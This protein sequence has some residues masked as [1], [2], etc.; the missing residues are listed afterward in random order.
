MGRRYSQLLKLAPRLVDDLYSGNLQEIRWKS[1]WDL[2]FGYIGPV[3]APSVGKVNSLPKKVSGLTMGRVIS[4]RYGS[5]F[6]AT[7]DYV[8]KVDPSLLKDQQKSLL[9]K[10]VLWRGP[11]TKIRGTVIHTHGKNAVMVRFRRGLPGQ[12]IGTSVYFLKT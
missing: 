7:R 8:I 11:H 5:A 3:S 2:K 12:A 10:K 9:D 6:H 1:D 4:P